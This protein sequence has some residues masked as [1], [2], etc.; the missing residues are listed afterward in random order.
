MEIK[1]LKRSLFQRI[2]GLSATSKPA[3]PGCWQFSAGKLTVDLTKAPELK[4]NGGAIRLEGG[5]LP[6]R[7]LV[8]RGDDGKYHAFHNRCTHIGHRR[9]D[10]VPGTG[11]VQC[12]SVGKSTYDMNGKNL[13]GPAPQPIREF[14]VAE[15]GEQLIV[16][17]S[18]T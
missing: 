10:P 1:F 8:I 6:M 12:C 7:I 13:Y 15:N 14:P 4:T 2:L 16:T 11:T 9:L 17:V 3:N 18:E 5:S